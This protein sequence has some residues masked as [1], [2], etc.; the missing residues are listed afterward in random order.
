MRIEYND[1]NQPIL[2]NEEGERIEDEELAAKQLLVEILEELREEGIYGVIPLLR[3]LKT[4]TYSKT[5][6][7]K[8][9]ELAERNYHRAQET[10]DLTTILFRGLQ[11]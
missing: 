10:S 1:Q 2:V 5:T 8:A 6:L 11:R 9:R 7:M 4:N 3:A